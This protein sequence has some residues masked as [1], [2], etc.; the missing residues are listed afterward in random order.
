[1]PQSN[2]EESR[3]TKLKSTPTKLGRIFKAKEVID[4]Y[5]NQ[6]KATRTLKEKSYNQDEV[7]QRVR[8][9]FRVYHGTHI[10]KPG[11]KPLSEASIDN[12]VGRVALVARLFVL[13]PPTDR[14]AHAKSRE[15]QLNLIFTSKERWSAFRMMSDFSDFKAIGKQ[16]G[17]KLVEYLN[18]GH[19]PMTG[20]LARRMFVLRDFKDDV[21]G[22]PVNLC[23]NYLILH[24]IIFERVA[25]LHPRICG[26]A[27]WESA[28]TIQN[29]VNND[30]L[31]LFTVAL[32]E[33]LNDDKRATIKVPAD[34]F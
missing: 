5:V 1:M 3:T 20:D 8:E 28:Q 22:V 19:S 21:I 14:A 29:R 26:F 9:D 12:F 30:L 2:D 4:K 17:E 18:Q 11:D 27:G 34:H 33:E 7:R 10:Q 25:I 24:Q 16:V 15:L 6:S 32:E 31:R 23:W 13:V